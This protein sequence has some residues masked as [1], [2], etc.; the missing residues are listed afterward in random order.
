M[1][2]ITSTNGFILAGGQ[3]RRMGRDKAALEWGDGS[4]LDHMVQLLSTV[5]GAVRVV[6]RGEL[7]D[8]IAGKGPLGGILTALEATNTEDNLIVAVDLPLLTEGFLRDFHVRFLASARPLVACRVGRTFPLCLGIRKSLRDDVARRLAED[9]LAIQAFITE[10]D[11]EILEEGFAP[12]LF[13]NANTPEDWKK[14]RE[15]CRSRPPSF[16]S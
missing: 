9:N 11:A 2:S 3:S 16:D 14:M 13:A 7:P 4:L 15:G 6:G 8:R 1:A 10:T 12:S 5:A